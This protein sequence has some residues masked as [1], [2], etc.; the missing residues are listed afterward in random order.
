LEKEKRR[1]EKKKSWRGRL[2]PSRV[3]R[4]KKKKKKKKKKK[5]LGGVE[6]HQS[7]SRRCHQ[8]AP[9]ASSP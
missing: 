7:S 8:L 2:E 9:P 5:S 3:G 1:G 4:E 6:S